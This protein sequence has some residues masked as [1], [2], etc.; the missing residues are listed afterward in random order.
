ML[1]TVTYLKRK[2]NR[3]ICFVKMCM[4]RFGIEKYKVKKDVR[5]NI[6]VEQMKKIEEFSNERQRHDYYKFKKKY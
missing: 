4:D 2:L 5:Y 6:S 1:Y 3:S